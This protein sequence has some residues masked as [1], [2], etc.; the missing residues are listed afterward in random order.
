[1]KQEKEIIYSLR[2]VSRIYKMGENLL[3]A[4]NKIDLDIYKGE[5]LAV[6]GPSGSGKSTLLNILGGMD[7]PNEGT[8]NFIGLDLA[9]ASDYKLTLYRRNEIGFVFQ[10]FNL[11]PTLTA[12][13]NVDVVSEIATN[14]MKPIEALKLVGLADRANH[15]PA[16]MSGGQ[17]QRVAIARAL[18]S[19]P[20][21]LL[22]DEPTG[23]LDSK[24]SKNVLSLLVEICRNLNRNV[25]MITHNIELAKVGDRVVKIK[26]GH[27]EEIIV[28]TNLVSVEELEW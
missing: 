6:I 21:V 27:I 13:E 25:I 9:I 14:P 3:Y 1:M 12:L 19:T 4:L 11:L 23:S 18:A 26:D 28:Q 5:F 2:G 22:C 16:E 24:T 15:F 8:V 10:F 20:K 17:Q 7:R